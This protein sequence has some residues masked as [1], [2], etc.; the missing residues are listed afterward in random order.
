MDKDLYRID[1]SKIEGQGIFANKKISENQTIGLPL[2]VIVRPMNS[3]T[4]IFSI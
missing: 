4:L 1:Q 3:G 2:Y